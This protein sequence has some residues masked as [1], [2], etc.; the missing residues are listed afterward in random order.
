MTK[1]VDT[2]NEHL[3]RFNTGVQVFGLMFTRWMDVIKWSHPTMTHLARC[4]M[5]GAGWL[6]S[7]Q[8]SGLRRGQLLSPGPRSFVAIKT[9]N[10]AIYEY[11]TNK[12]LIPGTGSSNDYHNSVPILENGKPPELG[13]W[14]EVFTGERVPL[15]ADFGDE[16]LTDEGSMKVSKKIARLLRQYMW[17]LQY[18]CV[19]DLNVVV[20]KFYPVRD[21]DRV[22]RV[23]AVLKGESHW[24]PDE[25]TN[26]I[27]AL[28][29]FSAAMGGPEQESEFRDLVF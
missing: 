4:A 28:V 10:D 18:D 23:V 12:K 20:R 16:V 19:D 6:H 5:G 3:T 7:S 15:D 25:L 13:W 9:L 27:P 1:S 14:F 24:T 22:A 2:D 29:Q 21:H 11:S 26:E 8:I 17:D